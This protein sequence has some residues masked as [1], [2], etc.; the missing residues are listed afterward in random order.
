MSLLLGALITGV[1]LGVLIGLLGF[2]IVLLHKATGVANFAQGA[3][4]TVAAFISL[5]IAARSGLGMLASAAVCVVVMAAVGCLVYLGLMRPAD[6]AGS[7]NLTIRTLALFLLLTSATR[8][9]WSHGQ[10]F[11]F[12]SVVPRAAAFSVGGA[13]VSW[14]TITT[15]L[16]GGLLAA[17]MRV[18]FARTRTGLTFLALAANVDV[19][20]LLGVR[21][22]R[23]TMIAWAFSAAVAVV[24]AV[25]I[26]PVSLVSTEMMDVYLLLGFAAAVVGGLDSLGGVFAGGLVV[27]LSSSV[28]SVYVNSET[29]VLVVFSIV[30]AMLVV[31]PQGIFGSPTMERL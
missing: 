5:E 14:L 13:P 4:A 12:E 20:R 19:A 24:V 27:G 18:F 25:L 8:L 21:A 28:T 9:I 2:S 15:I 29:S 6:T 23:L 26:A 31:R 30:L 10:P 11:S 3:F 22:R 1:A 17:A 7:L 16:V